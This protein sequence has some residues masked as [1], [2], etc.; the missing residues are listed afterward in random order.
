MTINDDDDDDDDEVL[1]AASGLKTGRRWVP[2]MALQVGAM[3]LLLSALARM[4][5]MTQCSG[6]SEALA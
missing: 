6:S 3:I 2:S 1:A 4:D 5:S